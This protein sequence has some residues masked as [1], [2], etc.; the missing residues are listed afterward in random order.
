MSKKLKLLHLLKVQGKIPD[1]VICSNLKRYKAG[2]VFQGFHNKVKYDFAQ[3]VSNRLNL[4]V[5]S[6]HLDSCA[7]FAVCFFSIWVLF[8]EHSRF[9][10]QHGKG[11]AISISLSPLYHFHMLH[12]HLDISCTITAKSSPLHIA[13]S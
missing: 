5:S 6:S 13:S 7:S 4:E 1:S 12:R 2:S 10:G 8:H 9:T 3:F 11:E